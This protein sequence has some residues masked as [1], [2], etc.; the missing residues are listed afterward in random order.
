MRELHWFSIVD[1][2]K[3]KPHKRMVREKERKTFRRNLNNA[4]P[5]LLNTL[6]ELQARKMQEGDEGERKTDDDEQ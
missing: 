2:L 4:V 5:N 1:H 3:S 6:D